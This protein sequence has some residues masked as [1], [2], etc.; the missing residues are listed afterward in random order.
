MPK[1]SSF[2]TF[3]D[4]KCRLISITK[5]VVPM[6]DSANSAMSQKIELR[7]IRTRLPEASRGTLSRRIRILGPHRS[8][9]LPFAFEDFD[10]AIDRQIGVENPWRH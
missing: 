4:V 9:P 5:V 6:H 8:L 1:R 3:T 10:L 7:G 2:R